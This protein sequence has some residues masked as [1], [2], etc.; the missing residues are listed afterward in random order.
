MTFPVSRLCGGRHRINSTAERF[1]IFMFSQ[2]KE[3]R[4]MKTCISRGAAAALA[5]ALAVQPAFPALGANPTTITTEYTD[6]TRD[7]TEYVY[8]S[9]GNLIRET[10]AM[11]DG[12][13]TSTATTYGENGL[14]QWKQTVSSSGTSRI[15]EESTYD[16][17]G[18][19]THYV[20]TREDG[21]VLLERTTS[22]GEDGSTLSREQDY[23]GTVYQFQNYLG[24][25]GSFSVEVTVSRTDGSTRTMAW[26]TANPFSMYLGGLYLDDTALMDAGGFFTVLDYSVDYGDGRSGNLH[27]ETQGDGTS[28]L[29]LRT[30]DGLSFLLTGNADGETLSSQLARG[31]QPAVSGA[32]RVDDSRASASITTDTGKSFSI[33]GWD[34]EF[35]T[36]S[37][38]EDGNHFL[39]FMEQEDVAELRLS[40]GRTAVLSEANPEPGLAQYLITYSHGDVAQEIL[41]VDE[42]IDGGS[43]L[44]TVY[45]DG[46]VK[47]EI[48]IN[49]T[50]RNFRLMEI[51]GRLADYAETS[52]NAG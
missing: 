19:V 38:T 5:L 15:T 9:S 4:N 33:S 48:L 21:T 28:S 35:L 14:P 17:S 8:D 51:I 24:E 42:G 10:R 37:D 25:D 3:M 32:W 40:N 7:Q 29:S 2:Y 45:R 43:K 23:L 39:T 20:K 18:N 31:D 30:A 11:A 50:E 44:R 6:G 27:M 26:S 47:E 49:D 34:G 46:T 41:E 1:P 36:F 13:R 22:Y 16:G 52:W 12:S